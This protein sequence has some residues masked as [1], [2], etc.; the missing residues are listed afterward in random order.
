VRLDH[1]DW[2]GADRDAWAALA[3]PVK[4]GARVVDALVPLGLLQARRGDPDAAAT[5][6]EATESA[7]ATG[8]LQWTAPVAAARAE[9]A[10]LHG[11]D[12]RA[13]EEAA[14]IFELAEQAR[15]VG[16]LESWPSGCGSPARRFGHRL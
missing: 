9:Y 7:F 16:S 1:G 11:D 3:E 8:E 10:W 6:Q 14:G 4:G 15:T 12:R 13:A 5:L 2:A